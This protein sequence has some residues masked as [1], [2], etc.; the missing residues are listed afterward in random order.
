MRVSC[1]SIVD[2][3]HSDSSEIGVIEPIILDDRVWC[4]VFA[5]IHYCNKKFTNRRETARRSILFRNV[6]RIKTT[7]PNNCHFTH[8]GVVVRPSNPG[9]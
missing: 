8:V 7:I 4:S 9:F 2:G 1:F 6:A 5:A 3:A